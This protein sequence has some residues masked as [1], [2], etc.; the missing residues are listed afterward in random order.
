MEERP[1]VL[2]CAAADAKLLTEH[3]D[4]EFDV[5][6][7]GCCAGFFGSGPAAPAR[8]RESWS[9]AAAVLPLPLLPSAVAVGR[10]RS[11]WAGS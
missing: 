10:G 3:G 5:F 2:Q 7:F 4:L 11:R 8:E 9:G 1:V 6:D